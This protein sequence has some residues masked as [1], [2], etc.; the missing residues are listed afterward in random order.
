M[1]EVVER[2]PHAHEY[3]IGQADIELVSQI[4]DLAEH[5]R[6]EQVS[7]EPAGSAGAEDTGK[8][9]ADLGGKAKC[10]AAAG[11]DEHSLDKVTVHQPEK[12][13]LSSI[14]RPELFSQL[15]N[16]QPEFFFK[17]LPQ[18]LGQVGHGR[19][20]VRTFLID[21]FK[22]LLGPKAGFA[23]A[24]ELRPEFSERKVSYIRNR[25]HFIFTLL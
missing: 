18:A 25:T 7:L 16:I 10:R 1:I 12:E 20:R 11:W 13:F 24:I 15:K 8:F 5:L 6:G 3:K 22:D 9:A 21:P 19:E 4:K 17:T 2:F 14:L 23:P